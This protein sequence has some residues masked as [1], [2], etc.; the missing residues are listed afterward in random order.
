MTAAESERYKALHTAWRNAY[1]A[2]NYEEMARIAKL[3]AKVG[4]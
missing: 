1:A 3:L 4:R 2:G